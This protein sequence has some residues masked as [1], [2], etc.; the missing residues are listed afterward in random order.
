VNI[1][2]F[3]LYLG[4]RS[5]TQRV[6]LRHFLPDLDLEH[7]VCS[8]LLELLYGAFIDRSKYRGKSDNHYFSHRTD[9]Q[10]VLFE[11]STL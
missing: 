7:S 3:T 2:F 5:S 6:A 8:R 1:F 9:K 10:L 4:R 11:L